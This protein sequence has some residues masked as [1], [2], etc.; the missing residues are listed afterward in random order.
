MTHKT[1]EYG[2]GLSIVKPLVEM[3]Q[4]IVGINNEEGKGTKF[5]IRLPLTESSN[6]SQ[7]GGKAR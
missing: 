7:G 2:L 4:G 1:G 3:H 5:I 6:N